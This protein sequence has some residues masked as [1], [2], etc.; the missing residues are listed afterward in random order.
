M[1]LQL[2]EK[3]VELGS[4]RSVMRELFEYGKKRAAAVGA[5]NV[6]DFSLGN[7][8]V[9][10]PAQV[11]ECIRALLDAPQAAS[12]HAYTSAQGDAGCR[13]AIA[14]SLNRRFA[15][16]A[17]ADDLYLTVGAAAS[18]T[19]TFHALCCPGDEVLLLAPFFA[20]YRVFVEGAGAMPVV[21]PPHAPDFEPDAEAVRTA[22]TPRTKAVVIN[23]PNNPSGV[24][25]S[26]E[27]LEKLAAVLREKAAE[28]GHPIF[29][30]TDE[31]YRELV[32]A[33]REAPWVPALYADTIVCYSYSKALSIPGERIGYIFVP[34]S[35]A[36]HDRVYA[37]VCGAGRKL[38]FVNAPALFQ[39]VAAA[40]DGVTVDV[41]IYER[42]AAFLCDAL[43]A[44]G[45]DCIP[46]QG[47]FYLFM[48]SPVPDAAAFC[49]KAKEFDLLLVPADSFSCPGW[50]RIAFCV[51][52]EQLQRSLP[53][54]EKLAQAFGLQK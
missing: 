29:L 20:E 11:D 21:V 3:S 13:A 45:F 5:E 7:P 30:V 26:R 2:P 10:P 6:Y 46:P 53:A 27:T 49:E 18:L 33:G 23:S 16:G 35:A 31:P 12:L 41:G 17:G 47:T 24:V 14:A 8:S 52:A 39:R 28:Y 32:F 48:K 1:S 9:E 43:T 38:G 15:A 22:L 34:Q 40:C 37:A 54:F 51:P 50:V 44:L 36:E 4:A 19:I 25:F 42:N